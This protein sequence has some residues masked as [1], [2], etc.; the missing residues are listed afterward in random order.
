MLF[1]RLHARSEYKGTGI[2]LAHCKKIVELRG[3]RIWVTSEP[4]IGSSFFFTVPK[5][6]IV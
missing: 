2:G 4:G 3:G 5:K 6:I 1:Q